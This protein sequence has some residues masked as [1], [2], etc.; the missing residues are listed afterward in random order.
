[1]SSVEVRAVQLPAGENPMKMGKAVVG[2]RRAALGEITNFKAA[3]VNTKKMGPAKA[4]FKP[5]VKASIAPRAIAVVLPM[6]L[7]PADPLPTVSE[8][9]ADVSMK[10]AEEELCQAFSDALLMVQ[11]V[12]EEDGDLPQLCSEYVKDIYSYL[13]VLEVEQA[14]RPDYMQHYEITERMR[15]LLVD[16]L[17]QVHSR[18]Q[19]LQETLYLTVAVMDRFL[20]VQPVSRR[21]LQLVGVTAMLVACKYEEMYA[22]EVAD[23]AYITDNAFTKAQILVMEQLILR[24]LNFELGRPLPLHFLRRASKVSNS[25]VERH[26]LAKYLMELTLLDYN[27]VHYRPSEIAAASLALSQLL[28][29]ALPWSPQ[30]QH[31]STYDAAHLKPIMQHI[32]KNIVMVNEGKTKFQAVKNKYSSSKLMKISLIPQLNLSIVKTMAAALLSNP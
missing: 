1:M 32:A 8:E 16:W 19:L 20:Q 15:A 25:D 31:Y 29:V 24:A 27:M 11:D 3:A 22:P 21:K 17:V 28:L 4:S 14:V 5:S 6:A 7:A 2:L 23:F 13:H 26:T 12:D 30:Q 10:E 18:F 9:S